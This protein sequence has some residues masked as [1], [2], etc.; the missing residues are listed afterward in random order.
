M[1]HEGGFFLIDP[2]PVT[3]RLNDADIRLMGNQ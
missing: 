2:E 1:E 3:G